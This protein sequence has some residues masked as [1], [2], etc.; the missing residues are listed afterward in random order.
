MAATIA[1]SAAAAYFS[2][3][4][5]AKPEKHSHP[6]QHGHEVEADP[7]GDDL[8]AW[9]HQQLKISKEQHDKLSP[10]ETAFDESSLQLNLDISAAEQELAA[11]VKTSTRNSAN[12]DQALERLNQAHAQLR[13]LTLD[14][15]F[16]MEQHLDPEQAERLRQWTHDSLIRQLQSRN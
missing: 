4:I 14:H 5:A 8:H 3:R 6:H 2:A 10:F 13:R 16:V 12:I 11:L 1:G 15:F 7:A 9:M